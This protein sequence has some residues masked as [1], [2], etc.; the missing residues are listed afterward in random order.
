MVTNLIN[1]NGRA[2]AN[3]F[4]IVNMNKWNGDID[5]INF[6]SYDSTVC[7]IFVHCGMGYDA[8]VVFGRDYDYSR[9]TM[10]HLIKFL[11]DYPITSELDNI[12]KV[13]EAIKKG[14]LANPSVR[15]SFD[16]TLY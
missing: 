15:V 2:V 11:S 9:T 14:H 4:V 1:S 10:K 6:Q 13:R 7:T 12:A 16:K 3:Q 5:N 8:H